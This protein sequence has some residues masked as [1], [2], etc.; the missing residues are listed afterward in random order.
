M[1]PHTAGAS[2]FRTERNLDRFVRNLERFR[3]GETLE[4]EIDKTLGY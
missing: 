3:G 1:T 4:G 2:Q